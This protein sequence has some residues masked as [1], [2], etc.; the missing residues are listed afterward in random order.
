MS[1]TN[2]QL[3]WR[4]YSA[5]EEL[6]SNV[7]YY[8]KY[9]NLPLN[10]TF[11][12]PSSVRFYVYDIFGRVKKTLTANQVTIT[13]YDMSVAGE[14]QLTA[15]Y[16]C[17]NGQVLTN[18][19]FVVR[20]FGTSSWRTLWSGTEKIALQS[21]HVYIN[22]VDMGQLAYACG[23]SD[24]VY[25]RYIASNSTR[26]IRVTYSVNNV[27][28]NYTLYMGETQTAFTQNVSTSTVIDYNYSTQAAGSID[29]GTATY[30]NVYKTIAINKYTSINNR[31][32]MIVGQLGRHTATES[33]PLFEFRG[34]LQNS[35]GSGPSGDSSLNG[36]TITI[37]KIEVQ[38]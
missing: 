11:S 29:S 37:T 16:T 4:Y 33:Y 15:S 6:R 14:Y 23:S 12:L 32:Q 20:V 9:T 36:Q 38:E 7:S 35:S 18:T 17:P 13:G 5:F 10:S 21:G 28:S 31:N 8:T 19:D 1:T 25:Y 24:D 27:V 3:G 22:D 2:Y 30:D 34:F 26:K